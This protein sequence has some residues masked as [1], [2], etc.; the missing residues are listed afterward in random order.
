MV[1]KILLHRY[2]FV[3]KTI[4]VGRM[5]K[6]KKRALTL[7]EMIVVMLLIAT[8]TGA[9]AY[10]YNESLNEGK[11]FKTREGISRIGTILALELAEDTALRLEDL[12]KNWEPIVKRS[13]LV[14]NPDK[15]IVDGW[16][17]HY[18][19]YIKRTN[20]KDEIIVESNKL[21]EFDARKGRKQ[22]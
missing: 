13:P 1:V 10:N 5:R 6:K 18:K 2:V 14:Q 21:K 7:I 16:G 15:F 9:I 11:A 3:T 20:E 22:S 4:K 12:E 17:Q 19:V 8:I